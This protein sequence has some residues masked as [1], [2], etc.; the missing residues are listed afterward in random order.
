MKKILFDKLVTLL[1]EPKEDETIVVINWVQCIY[2]DWVVKEYVDTLTRE[3]AKEIQDK[4]EK[5]EDWNYKPEDLEKIQ[6][7]VKQYRIKEEIKLFIDW[8]NLIENIEELLY[9]YS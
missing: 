9:L 7:E 8:K 2:E 6:E 1:V 5:Q 4:Y 3:I